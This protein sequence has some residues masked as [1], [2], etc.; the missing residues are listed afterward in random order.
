MARLPF[1]P[2]TSP[3]DELREMREELDRFLTTT[4]RGGA[5]RAGIEWEPAVDIS[6]RDDELVL[7]AELPGMKPE[8]IDIEVENNVLT[9]RGEKKEERE[10]KEEERY[11]YERQ[12][13]TFTRSFTLPRT[14]DPERITARFENGVLTIRMPKVEEARGR[15][16]DV[17]SGEGR[18]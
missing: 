7:S 3:L 12:Y 4:F 11:V 14:V 1:R 15:R 18:H 8:D 5:V 17:Q 6:D 9:I 2:G 10:R 13:G 16:I